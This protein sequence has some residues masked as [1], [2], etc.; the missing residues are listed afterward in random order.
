MLFP[1]SS[2]NGRPS[3]LLILDHVL[4]TTYNNRPH[5]TTFFGDSFDGFN[6]S[7]N[8]LGFKPLIASNKHTIIPTCHQHLSS[9]PRHGKRQLRPRFNGLMR[10]A[11]GRPLSGWLLPGPTII[12]KLGEQ[13]VRSNGSWD[14]CSH[15]RNR[16]R[17]ATR[18]T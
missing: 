12:L 11:Q 2:L 15:S 16:R 13:I 9:R 10:S 4:T 8:Q 14:H 3:M 17:R 1:E 18:C 5:L 7:G 6:K